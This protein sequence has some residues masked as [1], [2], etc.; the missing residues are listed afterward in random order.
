MSKTTA[1]KACADTHA[2]QAR[3]RGRRGPA[4]GSRWPLSGPSET[5]PAGG[6]ITESMTWITPL[7]VSMSVVTTLALSLR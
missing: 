6:R 5:Q 7:E 2:Y 1:S 4:F 3:R